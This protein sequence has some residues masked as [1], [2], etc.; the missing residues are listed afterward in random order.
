VD[1]QVTVAMLERNLVRLV[2]NYH[3]NS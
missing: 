2:E 1:A 3:V